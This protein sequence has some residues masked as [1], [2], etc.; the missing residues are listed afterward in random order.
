MQE[1][2]SFSQSSLGHKVVGNSKAK[3]VCKLLDWYT[4]V[5]KKGNK[6]TKTNPN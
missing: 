6:N 4:F 3:E 2:S 1:E 5:C